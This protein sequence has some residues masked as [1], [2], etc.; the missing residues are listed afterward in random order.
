VKQFLVVAALAAGLT[1]LFAPTATPAGDTKGPPCANII[2]GDI[3]Y[4]N[5]VVTAQVFLASS[6][7]DPACSGA[8]YSF[9]ITSTG[10]TSLGSSSN[11]TSCAA[12]AG[13]GCV[14][15]VIT[16]SSPDSVVC[17]NATTT[18]RGRLADYAPDTI[19]AACAVQATSVSSG[20]GASGGFG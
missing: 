3:S 9:D 11:S 7:T 8:T 17:V 5:G 19:D 4:L 14:E 1:V 10:G 20:T 16:P 12:P 15:F 6:P 13:Q 2:N 18:L